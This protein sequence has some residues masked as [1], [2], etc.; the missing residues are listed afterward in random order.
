MTSPV[1]VEQRSAKQLFLESSV[2]LPAPSAVEKVAV[3]SPM[4]VP[5][6]AQDSDSP[7]D[8]LTPTSNEQP[9]SSGVVSSSTEINSQEIGLGW[10]TVGRKG[11]T[12]SNEGESTLAQSSTAPDGASNVNSMD[13]EFSFQT[14]AKGSMHASSTSMSAAL[15]TSELQTESAAALNHAVDRNIV[16]DNELTLDAQLSHQQE[17]VA[18]KLP[19]EVAPPTM[20]PWSNAASASPANAGL[21][22]REIQR[23][24]ELRAKEKASTIATTSVSPG[25]PA[26][27][28]DRDDSSSI[29]SVRV[30]GAS[31]ATSRWNTGHPWGGAAT[32]DVM[33]NRTLNLREQ[34]RLEEERKKTA[35]AR[36]QANAVVAASVSG[37]MGSGNATT[38]TGWASLVAN[39]KPAQPVMNR[40]AATVVGRKMDEET[41]FWETVAN[42]RGPGVGVAN[43]MG[44]RSAPHGAGNG[45]RVGVGSAASISNHHHQGGSSSVAARRGGVVG[46]SGVGM[47]SGLASNK[48]NNNS[49]INMSDNKKNEHH[50]GHDG[51]HNMNSNNNNNKGN[52]NS[53]GGKVRYSNE[54]TAWC[55]ENLQKLTGNAVGD[56]TFVD[57]LVEMKSDAEIRDTILQNLGTSDDT[58]LFADEFVRRLDFER[59]SVVAEAGGNGAAG[60]KKGR[61]Q[62]ANNK[63]DPSL[64]LGFTS[65]SSRIMQGTIE[66]PEM[67]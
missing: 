50:H 52:S 49:N 11:R 8:S 61:K 28:G 32:T 24:E 23:Q 10:E 27:S 9:T 16:A 14:V 57:Y 47:G 46:A 1:D 35:A 7:E 64:V 36:E 29:Q 15:S 19:V 59:Q 21:S 18:E 53:G 26:T 62:R 40:P 43:N 58:R 38:K 2:D 66:M 51:G 30:A 5:P 56:R 31:G 54:F 39:S 48:T 3:S 6:L 25:V 33:K 42:V 34:M 67:K 44:G 37:N 22:L 4:D 45:G 63:V 12:A 55:I 41:S 65:T 13:N 20:A 17:Q 60:R